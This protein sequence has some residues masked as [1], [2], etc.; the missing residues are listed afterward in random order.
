LDLEAATGI[1][2]RIAGFIFQ[3]LPLVLIERLATLQDIECAV[4]E[5]RGYRYSYFVFRLYVL[6]IVRYVKLYV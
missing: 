2:V 5:R 6:F 4:L 3:F 1:V